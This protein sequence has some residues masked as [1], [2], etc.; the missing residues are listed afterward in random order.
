MPLG[1]SRRSSGLTSE[2]TSG[3]SGSLRQALEL[4]ITTA[5]A[6]A[7][8]GA[9]SL[10]DEPPL[11][12]SARSRPLKSAVAVSSTTMSRPLNGSVVP[13]ERDDAKKRTSSRGKL[14][15]SSRAR[16]TPPT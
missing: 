2:T 4:S 9:N 6:A 10:D 14:R 7:T 3:T 13:A 15:S 16:M 8:L 1:M 11:L 5:P 12:N